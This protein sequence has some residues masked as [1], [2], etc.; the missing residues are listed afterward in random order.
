MNSRFVNFISNCKLKLHQRRHYQIAVVLGGLLL[1]LTVGEIGLN[2]WVRQA[3]RQSLVKQ[4]G[5]DTHLQ[6]RIEWLS[7]ADLM[8]GRIRQ[9]KLQGSHCQV[10]GIKLESLRIDCRGFTFDLKRLLK[11]RQLLLKAIAPTIITAQITEAAATAYFVAR[12]GQFQPRITFLPG[13]LRVSGATEVFGKNVVLSLEG[14][15]HT[16]QPKKL[17]FYPQRLQIAGHPVSTGFL[18]YIGDRIPLEIDVLQEW[19]LQ[20]ANITLQKGKVVLQIEEIRF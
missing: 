2:I 5:P 13:R 6:A 17:R 3:L 10:S 4:P 20:I 8:A 15:V 1:L 14:L 9:L 12:Y 19:P 18:K 11:E 7:P 16:V